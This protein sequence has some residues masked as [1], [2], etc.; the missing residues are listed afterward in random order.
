MDLVQKPLDYHQ[1][2]FA[3]VLQANMTEFQS[4][5]VFFDRLLLVL[6]LPW[7]NVITSIGI[8]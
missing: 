6:R 1:A 3:E 4:Y 7:L 5:Y 2:R 8:G